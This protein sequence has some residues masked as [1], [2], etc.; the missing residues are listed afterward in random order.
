MYCFAAQKKYED[1]ENNESIEEEADDEEESKECVEDSDDEIFELA[2]AHS[3][4]EPNLGIGG[5]EEEEGGAV[6]LLVE[7]T[8]AQS[9]IE[10][11]TACVEKVRGLGE[12]TFLGFESVQEEAVTNFAGGNVDMQVQEQGA[13]SSQGVFKE[14]SAQLNA[15]L[16]P[17][18][19]VPGE[20][21][22]FAMSL[23]MITAALNHSGAPIVA[24]RTNSCP[25][26]HPLQMPSI[27]TAAPLGVIPIITF[28]DSTAGISDQGA[29][30]KKKRKRKKKRRRRLEDGMEL[31]SCSGPALPALSQGGDL[32]N[33]TK[34]YY[35]GLSMM[36]VPP[37]LE[38]GE[39]IERPVLPVAEPEAAQD[40]SLAI[41]LAL[42][43]N[44]E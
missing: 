28:P 29:T 35:S 8:A 6:D 1:P 25:H 24:P 2:M 9:R 27:A 18:K 12:A 21:C 5:M 15:G 16:S 7:S 40:P 19:A 31:F 20:T 32:S 39:L 43:G 22:D 14:D 36:Q 41:M 3:E 44:G 13:I 33:D 37:R 26:G 11:D 10:N 4:D 38:Y 17:K 23:A 30:S 42:K 34:G